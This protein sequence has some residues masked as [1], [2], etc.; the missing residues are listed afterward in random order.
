M[1]KTILLALLLIY[2]F[3]EVGVFD[4]GKIIGVLFGRIG[5]NVVSRKVKNLSKAKNMKQLTKFKKSDFAK[6]KAYKTSTIGFS[7]FETKLKFI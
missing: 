3:I 4:N 2:N 1:L 5:A 6:V 7:T